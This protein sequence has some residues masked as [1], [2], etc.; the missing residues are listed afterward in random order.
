MVNASIPPATDNHALNLAVGDSI[1]SVAC[2]KEVFQVVHEICKLIQRSPEQNAKLD[3]MRKQSNN[4]SKGIH[5]RC[6][7]IVSQPSK[8]LKFMTFQEGCF[9]T[10]N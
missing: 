7:T 10:R 1:E 8:C 6:P 5:A 2:L 3:E 4:D 9:V